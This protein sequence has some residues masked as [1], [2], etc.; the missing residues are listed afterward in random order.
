MDQ[1]ILAKI[2]EIVDAPSIYP[3]VERKPRERRVQDMIEWYEA[4]NEVNHWYNLYGL[5][6]VDAPDQST[7]LDNGKLRRERWKANSTFYPAGNAFPFDYT[8]VMRDKLLFEN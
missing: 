3:D 6:R 8:L 5:D 1:E 7:Y 4:N 2:D